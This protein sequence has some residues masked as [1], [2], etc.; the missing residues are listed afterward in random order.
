MFSKFEMDKI[1][2]NNPDV[3]QVFEYF[4]ARFDQIDKENKQL[5]ETNRQ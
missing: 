2:W 1:D 3:N 5:A 4:S